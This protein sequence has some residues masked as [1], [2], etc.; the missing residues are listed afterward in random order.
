M[1]GNLFPRKW[2]TMFCSLE[3]LDFLPLHAAQ[4]V[5][6][7]SSIVSLFILDFFFPLCSPI[8][9]SSLSPCFQTA[10]GSNSAFL[11]YI[12]KHFIPSWALSNKQ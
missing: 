11:L 5:S 1:K 2:N 4:Q 6:G 7:T 12:V 9:L 10:A 8:L 3:I